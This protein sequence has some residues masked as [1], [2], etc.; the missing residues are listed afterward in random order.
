[1][2][3]TWRDWIAPFD[4]V[5]DDRF[6]SI[7]KWS[8]S[9][10][11]IFFHCFVQLVLL[12]WSI[13]SEESFLLYFSFL[14]EQIRSIWLISQNNKERQ[15]ER[16]RKRQA[17]RIQWRLSIAKL[18]P[19]IIEKGYSRL[20]PPCVFEIEEEKTKKNRHMAIDRW[21]RSIF[22]V[23]NILWTSIRKYH[24]R[25]LHHHWQYGKLF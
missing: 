21:R 25:M 20:F 11:Q 1:M 12:Q 18:S 16:E 19:M 23:T 17:N 5:V 13:D 3:R 2:F 14:V 8:L 9:L 7:I 24:S 15:R 4:V 22:A 10:C 6:Q